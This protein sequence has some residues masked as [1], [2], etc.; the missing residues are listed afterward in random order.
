MLLVLTSIILEL[1]L[2][3]INL[4]D[5]PLEYLVNVVKVYKKFVT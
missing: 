5:V 1:F 4:T 3:D 2:I